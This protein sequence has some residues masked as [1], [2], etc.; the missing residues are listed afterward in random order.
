MTFAAVLDANVL[1]PVALADTLLRAAEAGLYRPLWSAR[2][3]AEVRSAIL[4]VHPGL[5]PRR[6]DVRLHAMN[7]AFD[8]ALVEGWQPLVEGIELGA[9]PDDRHVVAAALRGGAEAVVTANVQ[10]FP[11]AAMSA[12]GLHTVSPDDFLLDLADLDEETMVRVI[13]EHAQAK[14]WPPMTST[15]V[16]DALARAGVPAFARHLT[17]LTG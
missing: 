17:G 6:V 7:L 14:T 5:D 3:L 9:D 8:D 11:A 10:D 2:I 13:R 4:R 15:Q 12:L 1:V 16:L